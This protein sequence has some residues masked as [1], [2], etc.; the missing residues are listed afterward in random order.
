LSTGFAQPTSALPGIS[1]VAPTAVTIAL[2]A[3]DSGPLVPP[4]LLLSPTDPAANS[5]EIPCAAACIA[6]WSTC[7][8]EAG[9][10]FSPREY[11]PFMTTSPRCAST[12]R[13]APLVRSRLEV[14]PR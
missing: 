5:S 10:E 7:A 13:V 8:M 11:Q 3:G 4:W 6:V 1:E 14:V 9:L 2:L 12:A